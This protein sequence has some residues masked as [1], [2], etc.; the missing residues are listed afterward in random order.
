MFYLQSTNTKCYKSIIKKKTPPLAEMEGLDR[1]SVSNLS[2]YLVPLN[3]TKRGISPMLFHRQEMVSK[4]MTGIGSSTL[5]K[6]NQTILGTLQKDKF[7]G[8]NSQRKNTI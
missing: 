4:A 2:L 8:L 5:S 6:R 3:N 7:I 1:N